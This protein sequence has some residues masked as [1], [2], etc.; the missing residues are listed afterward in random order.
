MMAVVDSPNPPVHLILGAVAL[1][2]FRAK[3]DQWNQEIAAW[4]S[5]TLGA[6]F[7]EAQ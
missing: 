4:E 6:D 7:P 5:T 3:L 1:K 2:R